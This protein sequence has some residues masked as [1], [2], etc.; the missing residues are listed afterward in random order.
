MDSLTSVWE[1]GIKTSQKT[2]TTT[3]DHKDDDGIYVRKIYSER[4]RR[5]KMMHTTATMNTE[6]ERKKKLKIE[7]RED[8][9]DCK[10]VWK[11]STRNNGCT[12]YASKANK[13]KGE[14]VNRGIW[15]VPKFDQCVIVRSLYVCMVFVHALTM[16]YGV[17]NRLYSIQSDINKLQLAHTHTHKYE[18][19]KVQWQNGWI[20]R[21]RNIET[22]M[23]CD[24]LR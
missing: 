8:Y 10:N 23:N 19:I 14:L 7:R 1:R 2:T 20:W 21:G 12:Q 17:T 15:H 22:F 4:C 24:F 18:N 5:M 11:K 13:R 6:R 9:I 3:D 16:A